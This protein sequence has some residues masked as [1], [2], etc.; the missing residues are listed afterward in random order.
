MND[1]SIKRCA[2]CKTDI[3]IPSLT[4][5]QKKEIKTARK[6]QGMGST[7]AKIREITNL[8][9]RDSKALVIH[10]YEAGHCNRCTYDKLQ[11]ENQ[12]CPRCKSF[13]LNW[14]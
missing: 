10:I 4:T 13:N 1:F 3:R 7:L 11:G 14:E 8:D 9:L 5:D 12:I 6:K 2:R